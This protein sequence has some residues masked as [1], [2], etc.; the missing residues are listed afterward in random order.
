MMVV[1][2]MMVMVLR[3]SGARK[4]YD[5]GE[6]QSFFHGTYDSNNGGR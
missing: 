4:E 1:V 5:H 2:T 6:Q 3:E